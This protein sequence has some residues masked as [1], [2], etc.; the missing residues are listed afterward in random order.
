V[1]RTFAIL[2]VAFVLVAIAI[3]DAS[4]PL[5][6]RI[7][8]P[9]YVLGIIGLGGVAERWYVGHTR[10][11]M[12]ATAVIVALVSLNVARAGAVVVRGS[13]TGVGYSA[14][15]W[16][17]SEVLDYVRG[18]PPSALIVSNAPDVLWWRTGREACMVPRHT[19]PESHLEQSRYEGAMRHLHDLMQQGGVV[20]YLDDAEWRWYLPQESQVA[21]ALSLVP[22]A[23]LRDGS[24]YAASR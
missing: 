16:D 13:T 11:R 6:E 7:L 22:V 20:V 4:T 21:A 24:V 3:A 8:L 15:S 12:V 17:H 18:L 14:D 2:Y 1:L 19:R 23:R 10:T 5:D 9:I